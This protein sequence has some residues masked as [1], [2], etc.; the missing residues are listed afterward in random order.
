LCW[1]ISGVMLYEI[2]IPMIK[3]ITKML[4]AKDIAASETVPAK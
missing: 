4:L 1:A 2:P 3:G